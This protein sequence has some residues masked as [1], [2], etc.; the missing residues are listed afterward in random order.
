VAREVE[1]LAQ[2]AAGLA[3]A[4]GSKSDWLRQAYEAVRASVPSG[5]DPEPQM[6]EFLHDRC[7]V[8]KS[9]SDGRKALRERVTGFQTQPL[10]PADV[11]RANGRRLQEAG[12]LTDDLKHELGQ[13]TEADKYEQRVQL[14]R[15]KSS[16]Q[17]ASNEHE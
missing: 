4:Q 11:L 8:L 16:A 12:G 2:V 9:R 10:A 14:A 6:A 13:E 5:V 1:T 15:D 17:R 3:P 7:A